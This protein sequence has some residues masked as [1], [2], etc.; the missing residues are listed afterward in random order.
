MSTKIL[1]YFFSL[2]EVQKG[3]PSDVP[4]KGNRRRTKNMMTLEKYKVNDASV[5]FPSRH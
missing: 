5:K 1:K 2:Y 3:V 4:W